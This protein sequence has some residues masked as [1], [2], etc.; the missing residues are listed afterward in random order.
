MQF[1][2]EIANI[3]AKKKNGDLLYTVTL[4]TDNPNVLELGAVP[5]DKT[6]KVTVED[7]PACQ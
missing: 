5:A 6:V 1:I 7:D 2:A 3:N 4:H